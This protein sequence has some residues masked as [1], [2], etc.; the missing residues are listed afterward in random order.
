MRE[1]KVA[2]SSLR[3]T[4]GESCSRKRPPGVFHP[5]LPLVEKKRARETVY[6]NSPWLYKGKKPEVRNVSDLDDYSY[7]HEPRVK[8]GLDAVPTAAGHLVAYLAEGEH[9]KE[10]EDLAK[11]DM[12]SSNEDKDNIKDSKKD[13][14]ATAA[15]SEVCK[16]TKKEIHWLSRLEELRK[17]KEL[18][19]D[20]LV[21]RGYLPNPS[22][23]SWVRYCEASELIIVEAT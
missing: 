16:P 20:C 19:G 15:V 8:F 5:S 21:P 4:L 17:Y 10:M 7:Q 18:N 9:R 12:C 3:H 11:K 23:G 2:E 14:M 6:T 22:L 13:S 1:Q